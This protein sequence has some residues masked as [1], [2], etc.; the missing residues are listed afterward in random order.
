MVIVPTQFLSEQIM[1]LQS[2]KRP[3]LPHLVVPVVVDLKR[4]VMT[5]ALRLELGERVGLPVLRI[6]FFVYEK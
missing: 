4:G 5:L 1:E 3:P 6:V 2:R